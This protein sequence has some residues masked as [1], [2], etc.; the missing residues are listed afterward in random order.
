MTPIVLVCT[1]IDQR[2]DAAEAAAA[3]G[4]HEIIR[5]AGSG[6]STRRQASK[7]QVSHCDGVNMAKKVKA[8]SYVECSSKTKEGVEEVFESAAKAVIGAKQ[9]RRICVIL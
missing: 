7:M 3:R 2:V 5:A 8:Y 9:S 4:Q 6:S 1:K